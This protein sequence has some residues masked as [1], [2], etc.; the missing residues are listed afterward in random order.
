MKIDLTVTMEMKNNDSK[1]KHRTW[2]E[3]AHRKAQAFG[4]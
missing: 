2:K 1:N 4:V 3:T